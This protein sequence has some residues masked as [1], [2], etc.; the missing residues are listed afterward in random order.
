MP[1]LSAASESPAM[2]PPP[3]SEVVLMSDESSGSPAGRAA[4]WR[5]CQTS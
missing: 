4:L 2:R 1:T 5:S 3:T